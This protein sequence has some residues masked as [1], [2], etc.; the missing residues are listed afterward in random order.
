MHLSSL[1]SLFSPCAYDIIVVINLCF[2][3]SA[4]ISGLVLWCLLFPL[5]CPLNPQLVEEDGRPSWFWFWW[6]FLPVKR[7][8]FLS[9][10]ASCTLRTGDW[11][12][13]KFQCNN[14]T[15][16]ITLFQCSVST[17]KGGLMLTFRGKNSSYF[18]KVVYF[19]YVMDLCFRTN[20]QEWKGV[21]VKEH[22]G[23]S[24]NCVCYISL[25]ELSELFK[26]DNQKAEQINLFHWSRYL[27]AGFSSI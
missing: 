21:K 14:H 27:E 16:I 23:I 10:V 15:D 24:L 20:L 5:S 2:S 9:T 22:F 8:F 3:L 26:P 18:C 11:I 25:S 1:C 12:R 4:G 13:E 7:E 19:G 6:R 17:F